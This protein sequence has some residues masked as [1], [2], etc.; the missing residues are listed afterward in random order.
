MIKKITALL[1]SLIIV[2]GTMVAFASCGGGAPT[3]CTEHKDE[4]GD[5]ICDTEGC[6]EA[7]E[8]T[9]TA[10]GGFFNEKGELILFK[11]GVP[12]FTFVLGTDAMS[13]N[14]ADVEDLAE[15]LVSLSN[16]GSEIKTVPQ[17]EAATD[18]EILVGTVTNRGD[19]YKFNKYDFGSKGY[20]VKQIGTKIVVLG[21]SSEATAN[22]IS[23]LKEKVFGIK[24]S[25]EQFTDFVMAAETNYTYIQND[26]KITSVKVDGTSL[27]EFT[28]AYASG[29]KT[30]EGIAT[31]LQDRLYTSVGIRCEV[32]TEKNATGKKFIIRTIE[33]DGEGAGFYANVNDGNLTVECEYDGKFV[34]FFDKFIDEC[35]FG[36]RGDVNFP[37]NFNY[38]I[39]YRT[40]TYEQFGANGNDTLDDFTAIKAAHEEANKYLLKVRADDNATYYLYKTSGADHISI[41][42]DTN[43]G[44]ANFVIIDSDLEVTDAA[45]KNHI[46]KIESDNSMLRYYPTGSSDISK[47]LK[48]INENGG[49]KSTE[50]ATL[51]F[52]L[53][54]DA[55]VYLY[56]NNHKNYVRFGSNKNTGEAQREFIYLNADGT[57]ASDTGLLFDY[58]EITHIDILFVDDR[59][60]TVD[61]GI[62]TTVANQ[63][64]LDSSFYV[65]RGINVCRSNATVQNIKH[66]IEGEGDTGAPYNGFLAISECSG[67]TIKDSILT[68]HKTYPLPGSSSTFMGT[69]DLAPTDCNRLLIL[70]V[71]QSN[72]FEDDGV[73]PTKIGAGGLWGIMGSNRCKNLTYEEC[74][75]SR[76]DAHQGTLGAKIIKSNVGA[77]TLIGG[78]KFE[79]IES[80]VYAQNANLITLREDYGSLW[81]GDILV[82]DTEMVLPSTFSANT[83]NILSAYWNENELNNPGNKS[84]CEGP[85]DFGY[86][87]YMPRSIVLDNFTVSAKSVKNIKLVSGSAYSTQ[88]G[89]TKNKHYV[90]E[91]YE[92]IGKN[93][94]YNYLDPREIYTKLTFVIDGVTQN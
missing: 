50:F 51:D 14:R 47:I 80:K 58:T 44:N 16:K 89:N 5:G 18:V 77:I 71:T 62:F 35:L 15:V 68:A 84:M 94:A 22:A 72:F 81:H 49:I 73:T 41:K 3:E 53:G 52:G 48:A 60:I 17:G 93:S 11:G 7:V 70:R 28:I 19:E 88:T 69:Y 63:M 64:S 9:P 61:G 20:I 59:P 91:H 36:K 2:L 34:E 82:K 13:K 92:I 65:K 21:G 31:T 87:C 27:S 55:L 33:N 39:D 79:L 12:T 24:R 46:F 54:R 56:N 85:H 4:N 29:D 74:T 66:Y 38:E 42:T 67:V 25:N 23:H 43:W 75:L 26:Y 83:V 45:A 57:V 8:K 30:A 10:D 76:F 90:P 40:V 78:G 37:A 1:L 32:K 6:G 86:D